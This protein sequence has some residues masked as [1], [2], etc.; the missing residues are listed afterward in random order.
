M[1]G[2]ATVEENVAHI[3]QAKHVTN[4]C[5]K[6]LNTMPGHNKIDCLKYKGCRKCWVCGPVGFLKTY[7]CVEEKDEDIVNDPRAD[8]YNYVNLD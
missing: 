3:H 2:E 4:W 6:C 1:L 7:R 5:G 8:V